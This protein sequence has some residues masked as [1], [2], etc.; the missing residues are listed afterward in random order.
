MPEIPQAGQRQAAR[1]SKPLRGAIAAACNHLE[2]SRSKDETGS[3]APTGR[4]L[5]PAD[6]R[7]VEEEKMPRIV[8]SAG[9]ATLAIL[10][11]LAATTGA[12]AQSVADF[13][14][15]KQIDFLTGGSPGDVYDQ[16]AR[17]IAK[18]M[19]KQ[20]PGNPSILVRSM[21]G[22][23]NL[24]VT[25][26]IYNQSPRDGTV[27][28]MVSRDMPTQEVLQTPA[29]KFKSM[30]FNWIGSPEFTNRVCA[31]Y[32]AAKVQKAEDLF[33]EELLVG[34][35]GAGSAVSTT[36]VLLN[37]LL[38]MKL[39]LVE[40]YAGGPEVFLAMERGEVEGVCQTISAIESTR[41]GWLQQGRVQI[42]FN[43][44]KDP[45][46]GSSVPSVQSLAK[47]DEQRQIIAFYNSN[48]GLGR[49]I[50][51]TPGVPSDRVEALRRAFDATMKDKDF[52]ADAQTIHVSVNP[53]TGEAVAVG[54][55]GIMNTPKAI[56][57]K[58]VALVG[59][60]GE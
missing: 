55:A 19:T 32:S 2:S 5:R 20:I 18:Y 47:T 22:G 24:V 38:G 25:N 7:S 36:P 6:H 40:G 12:P 48:V 26:Y 43:L 21:P 15:G 60:L 57:D 59:K 11:W 44:E 54:I 9:L 29:V 56:V 33:K 17:L 23:G 14:H 30:E 1:G 53:Q 49:P 41:P 3:Q 10:A 52:L 34:G 42:L 28:G 13:Y 37:K 39:K 51:T 58:T 4:R 46:P 35:T 16:W 27:L 50:L 45:I 8:E 31:A